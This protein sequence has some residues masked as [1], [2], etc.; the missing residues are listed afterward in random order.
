MSI[1]TLKIV[2][3]SYFHSLI[4]YGIIFWGNSSLSLQVFKSQK[5]IIR[6]MY[7]LCTMDSC[8]DAFKNLHI[9]PLKSQYTYCLLLFIVNNG[10]LY[11]TVSHIHD[12]QT[13]CN[14]DL[15]QPHS[16]LTLYQKG[17][18]YSG[19][20]L[21]NSLPLNIKQLAHNIVQLGIASSTFLHSKSCYTVE[22]YF[23]HV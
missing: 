22:E 9:L 21:F 1:D 6:I 8:R 13:R 12:I 16:H 15:F 11:H 20:K 7:G 17:P 2:Y 3:Y 19:I 5:R 4:I 10:D 14:F 18:Y 23:I